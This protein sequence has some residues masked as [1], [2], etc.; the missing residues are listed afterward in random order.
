M[1]GCSGAHLDVMEFENFND[2]FEDAV[3][4]LGSIDAIINCIGSLIL[5]PAHLTSEDELLETM[6]EHERYER[7]VEKATLNLENKK[8]HT[9]LSE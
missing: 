9:I 6:D 5:K 2:F 1:Y 7:G 8:T 4:H 3:R